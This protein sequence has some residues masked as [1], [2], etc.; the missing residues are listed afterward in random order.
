V[1]RTLPAKIAVLVAVVGLAAGTAVAYSVR[2]AQRADAPPA[3]TAAADA[4]G[5]ADVLAGPHLVFRST[6][7][8]STYGKVAAVPLAEPA[9]PPAITDT[10]CERVYAVSGEGICLFADRG[11]ITTYSARLL[12]ARL[13]PTRELEITGIP[14]R[15]RV[16]P[17]GR[18]AAATTF[19]SGHSYSQAGFSTATTIYE[20]ASGRSL[21][22]LEKFAI[23]KDGKRYG[24]PDVNMW[25]VTFARDGNSFYATLSTNGR[26]YLV[27][28][29]VAKR[30]LQVLADDV[31]CP[32]LSPDET[33]VAYKKRA[34]GPGTWRLHVR[35]LRTGTERALAEERSV[36]DQVEWLDDEQV[37]YGLPRDDSAETDVWVVPADGT[38]APR[39]LVPNAWSPAVVR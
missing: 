19:V 22:N 32:S 16:S 34:G 38:G 27:E 10:D 21:G 39:L 23:S 36:D 30:E 2:A 11:V 6:A 9:G 24:S 7:L 13:S 8:G 15:A 33:K 25:G 5:L 37:L 26:I 1:T 20:A 31:E 3:A 29:D 35:D 17:D 28:G 12:D 18:L 14:S 4:P